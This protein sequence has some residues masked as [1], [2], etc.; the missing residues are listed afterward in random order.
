MEKTKRPTKKDQA[1]RYIQAILFI[2]FLATISFAVFATLFS[3]SLLL[4]IPAPLVFAI[5]VSSFIVGAI[6]RQSAKQVIWWILPIATSL[7]LFGST[8]NSVSAQSNECNT[9]YVGIV[10]CLKV[11]LP[12]FLGWLPWGHG[13]SFIAPVCWFSYIPIQTGDCNTT[14]TWYAIGPK[15]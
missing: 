7:M 15:L 11:P 10:Q 12:D 14:A 4:L 3:P 9:T 6:R 13:P 8:A 5:I 2:S 1:L